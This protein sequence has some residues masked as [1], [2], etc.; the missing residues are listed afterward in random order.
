M[1]PDVLEGVAQNKLTTAD[2]LDK[3]VENKAFTPL[4][5]KSI[6][7]N[8]NASG[9]LL[10][11]LAEHAPLE[12]VQNYNTSPGTLD[13]IAQI[14][15]DR[16]ALI[17]KDS[18][19]EATSQGVASEASQ[20]LSKMTNL[21]QLSEIQK[22]VGTLWRTSNWTLYKMLNHEGLSKDAEKTI[23]DYTS[24]HRDIHYNPPFRG[25]D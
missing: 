25:S 3:L 21:R 1:H 10:E 6:A 7:K 17:S 15:L 9:R 2:T 14:S 16:Y 20:A 11:R 18:T 23:D 22:R 12:V 24:K 19:G 13:K 4:L 5:A 8:P